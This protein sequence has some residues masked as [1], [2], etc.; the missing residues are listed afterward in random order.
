M[1]DGFLTNP[2]I[3]QARPGAFLFRGGLF[4]QGRSQ[5][6][7]AL[8]GSGQVPGDRLAAWRRDN[9]GFVFQFH[10]LLPDFTALENML[11]PVRSRGRVGRK[12]RERALEFLDTM[13]LADRAGHLPGERFAWQAVSARPRQG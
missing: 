1:K 10:F 13:G 4:R 5:R 12:D 6:F 11:I 3:D 7:R 9:L 8:P 2:A